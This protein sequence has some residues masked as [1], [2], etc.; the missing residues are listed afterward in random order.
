[1]GKFSRIQ[2]WPAGVGVDDLPIPTGAVNT[3]WPRRRTV[4]RSLRRS[5]VTAVLTR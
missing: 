4:T 3:T 1:M 5:T 2:K